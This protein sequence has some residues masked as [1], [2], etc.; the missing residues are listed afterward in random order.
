MFGNQNGLIVV[1]VIAN[2]N[3]NQNG[4]GNVVAARLKGNENGLNDN[5]IMCYNYR[6]LGHLARNYTTKPRKRDAAF[7]QTQLLIAQKEEAVIQIQAEEFD[8][9]AGV[10]D[11][12]EIEEVNTNCILMANLQQASSSG[13]QTNNAPVY[14]L[15]GSA[16]V[17]QIFL[18]CVDS[19]CSKNMTGNLKLL[20]NFVWKFLGTVRFGNGHIAAILDY[21]DYQWGNILITR[22][23]LVEGLRH[24]LFSIVQFFDSDLEAEAIANACYTQNHS[25]IHRCFDKT[26]Y[27]LING[28]K[29]DISFLH[30]FGALCYPKNDHE[31]IGKL[32]AKAMA[33]EQRSSNFGLQ[34]TTY[35][36]INSGLDLTY[37]PSTITTQKPTKHELDLLFKAMYDDYIGGQ[38]SA[39]PRTTSAA[40]APQ[41]LQTL[42]ASTT[43]ADTASITFLNFRS[44]Y[45]SYYLSLFILVRYA[46][47]FNFAFE[48]NRVD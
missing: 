5:Q 20:I 40:Q 42:M 41:V 16:E 47:T 7:L 10:G 4:N 45:D 26:P 13:T 33:F 2:L 29:P 9:M 36:Q 28:R 34:S 46:F 1:P 17:V 27:E 38:S 6:G 35:G 44:F 30:V 22:V 19:G 23:Y 21:G 31:D 18:W 48:L 15:D 39:T 12:E 8:F 3:A 11:L 32:G 37:A 43:I 25:I 24:N 14:N